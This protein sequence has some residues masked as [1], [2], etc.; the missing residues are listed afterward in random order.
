M[1]ISPDPSFLDLER[2]LNAAFAPALSQPSNFD[3]IFHPTKI[4]IKKRRNI[5]YKKN[6]GSTEQ[7]KLQNDF[8]AYMTTAIHRERITYLKSK[9][10]RS[11]HECDMED[12]N[13][14]FIADET[15]F[16]SELCDSDLIAGA[17]RTLT[18]KERYVLVARAI[19]GKDFEDI[20][21]KLGMKY[22]GVAAIYYRT[23]AK[24]REILGGKI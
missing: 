1:H 5:M 11:Q 21:D 10:K 23:T 20:A 24:L 17:L 7:E 16:V 19:H 8:T 3:L 14:E 22:K 18:E 4:Q 6:N 9:Y 2:F 15:D 13:M 12:E